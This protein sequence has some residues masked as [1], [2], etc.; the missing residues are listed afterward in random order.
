MDAE[1]TRCLLQNAKICGML[2]LEHVC[3]VELNKP[4]K[5]LIHQYLVKVRQRIKCCADKAERSQ[6]QLIPGRMAKIF[7]D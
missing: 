3:C 1:L 4:L 6:V 5:I 7:K 2:I